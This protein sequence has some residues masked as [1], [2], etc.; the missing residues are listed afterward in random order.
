MS[1]ELANLAILDELGAQL[2]A[3]FRASEAARVKRPAKR[4]AVLALTAAVGAAAILATQAGD[5]G[6][7]QAQAAARVLGTV[8][9]AAERQPAA[10]PGPRQYFF[11]EQ[12]STVLLPIRPGAVGLIPARELYGP[13]A[14]VVIE[15]WVAWSPTRAGAVRTVVRSVTFATQSARA[16]WVALG[17]PPLYHGLV[18]G[19]RAQSVAAI[20]ERIPLAASRSLSVAQ[21]LKLPADAGK[22]YRIVFGKLSAAAAFNAAATLNLYPL[23]APVRAAMYRALARVHGIVAVTSLRSLGGRRVVA[24]GAPDGGVEDEIVLDPT[25]GAFIGSR[26]VTRGSRAVGLALGGVRSQT[27]VVKRTIT[28]RPAPPEAKPSAPSPPPPKKR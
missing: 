22:L 13:H 5:G 27:Y 7:T 8:A 10:L 2:S 18:V 24:L 9:L 19:T 14:R 26:T 28:N 16:R 23:R 20:G 4:A 12:R 21:L 11:V 15:S 6:T 25:T 1:E 17:R 3:G